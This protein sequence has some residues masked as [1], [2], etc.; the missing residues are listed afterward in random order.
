MHLAADGLAV[1][2]GEY[3]GVL[4]RFASSGHLGDGGYRVAL[5]DKPDELHRH[6]LIGQS[7]HVLHDFGLAVVGTADRAFARLYPFD[8]VVEQRTPFLCIR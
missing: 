2:D 1:T 3:V 6:R 8:V 4:A 7:T 5:G